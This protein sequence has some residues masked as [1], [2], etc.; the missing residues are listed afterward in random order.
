MADTQIPPSMTNLSA[1]PNA[2]SA[3]WQPILP[4]TPAP[5]HPGQSIPCR[6]NPGAIRAR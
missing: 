3:R 2:P 4:A 6:S 5:Q 1:P